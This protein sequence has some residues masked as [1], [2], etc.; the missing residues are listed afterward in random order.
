MRSHALAHLL[1]RL[2]AE[3]AEAGGD[4]E[5]RCPHQREAGRVV[6]GDVVADEAQRGVELALVLQRVELGSEVV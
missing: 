4:R 1:H 2:Y 3:D 6:V 5:L